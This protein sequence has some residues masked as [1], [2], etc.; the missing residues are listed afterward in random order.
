MHAISCGSAA[1]T[2]EEYDALVSWRRE[3][4][5]AA[6]RILSQGRIIAG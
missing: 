2:G 5:A 6:A 3:Q 1:I 4:S